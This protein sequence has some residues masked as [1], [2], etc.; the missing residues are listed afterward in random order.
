MCEQL[1]LC[2]CLCG[3]SNS[4]HQRVC[5]CCHRHT[6]ASSRWC[7]CA[8]V[9]VWGPW[10][11]LLGSL[12]LRPICHFHQLWKFCMCFL[13]SS[14]PA[15]P[16]SRLQ[17]PVPT[18]VLTQAA[19]LSYPAAI[20]PCCLSPSRLADRLAFPFLFGLFFPLSCRQ[21][22]SCSL[23]DGNINPQEQGQSRF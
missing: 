17:G 21:A 20:A 22:Q 13:W 14:G 16:G 10:A 3:C 18:W 15:S 9:P 23:T 8:R 7:L 6:A 4:W 1:Q 5:I 2:V 11:A 19:P 12:A